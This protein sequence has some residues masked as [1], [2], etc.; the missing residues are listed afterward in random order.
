MVKGSST[1]TDVHNLFGDPLER[2]ATDLFRAKWWR[3][4]YG[5][6]G[7]L[8]VEIAELEVYFKGNLVEDYQLSVSRNRY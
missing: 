2:S 1:M 7:I 3:Y 8:G 6:L 5:Y 4:R